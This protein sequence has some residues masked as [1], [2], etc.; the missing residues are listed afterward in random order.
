MKHHLSPT[1]HD[2]ELLILTIF[3]SGI[4]I[5]SLKSIVAHW[6][7]VHKTF[8]KNSKDAFRVPVLSEAKVFWDYEMIKVSSTGPANTL[9]Y[10]FFMSGDEEG[11]NL[12]SGYNITSKGIPIQWKVRTS[13]PSDVFE[14]VSE[15]LRVPLLPWRLQD[16]W[17]CEQEIQNVS[18]L[19]LENE[20]LRASIVPQW[21]GKIWS[22][23]DK[24]LNRHMFFKNPAHQPG[25]IG[26]RKAWTSGGCEWNWSPGHIG[27][28]VF[29]EAP[30]W[31]AVLNTTYGPIVRVWEFDR[32]NSSVWQVDMLLYDNMLLVHPKLTNPNDVQINGYWW[33]CVAMSID[34]PRNRILAPSAMS[35]DNGGQCTPW[36]WGNFMSPNTSFHGPDIH[37]DFCDQSLSCA[38]QND[39]SFVGNIPVSNDFFFYITKNQTPWIAFV[40]DDGYAVVHSHPS[41]LNGTKFFQW[42]WNEHGTWNQ[43]FL[44]ATNTTCITDSKELDA[45]DPNCISH[46]PGRYTELQVGPARTQMHTFPLPAHSKLEWTEWFKAFLPEEPSILRDFGYG[47]ATKAVEK[48]LVNSNGISVDK[49]KTL[50][51]FLSR[52]SDIPPDPSQIVHEGMPWGGLRQKLI[53]KVLNQTPGEYRFA[54]G[55]PFPEPE[56]DIETIP[57]LELLETGTFSNKTLAVIPVNFEL[58]DEWIRL[59]QVAVDTNKATWLHYLYLGTHALEVGNIRQAVKFFRQSMDLKKSVYA[60][61]N[62]A[63]IATTKQEVIER[64]QEAWSLWNSLDPNDDPSVEQLGSDLAGEICGWMIG[65]EKWHELQLFLDSLQNTTSPP[66]KYSQILRKDRVLHALAA[67]FVIRREFDQAISILRENCFPTYGALRANLLKLWW[68]AQKGKAQAEKG[69][70][71][72]SSFELLSLRKRLRCDGDESHQGIDDPCICG[73]PNLGYGY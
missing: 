14:H 1:C 65:N 46:H 29:T 10:F 28:S 55:C 7:S 9:P 53:S 6:R 35:I 49:L 44:S 17:G 23:F 47:A 13:C 51:E 21:G 69:N 3:L 56:P 39:M 73:P 32:Q 8:R 20:Y 63:I 30:V 2:I 11:G 24:T 61:R 16:D 38:W 36:P 50:D 40:Q 15:D 66:N 22:L 33:T 4:I 72:L 5:Q 52:T 67:I 12:Y 27:H 54:P 43:D 37:G 34:S 31:T 45:Y 48:W 59:L 18:V 64:Y 19:V 62:L 25:N 57:W 41:F 68:E 58:S 70:E 71:I 60:A 26:Y 42:G